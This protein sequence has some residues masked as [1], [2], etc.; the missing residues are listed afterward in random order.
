MDLGAWS[1]FSFISHPPGTAAEFG[2]V[3]VV[4]MS[5]KVPVVVKQGVAAGMNTAGLSCDMQTL[6]G[7]EYPDK[8]GGQ[9]EEEDEGTDSGSSNS[10][11]TGVLNGFFCEW[12]LSNYATAGEVADALRSTHV[13]YG[14]DALGQHFI[15]RD[16]ARNS[17]VI[18]FLKKQTLIHEDL[19]DAESGFGIVTNEPPFPWHVENVKHWLWKQSLELPD[20]TI[21]SGFYP[22]LRFLRLAS[23]KRGLPEADSYQTVIM[24]AVHL[25]NSVTIPHGDQIGTDSGAGEGANDHT[26]FGLVYDHVG[27]EGEG[28]VVYFRSYAN[29]S[30]QRIRLKDVGLDVVGG[31]TKYMPVVNG[32]DWFVDAAKGFRRHA[33][34]QQ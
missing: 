4:P 9:E 6:I 17:I 2:Y 16:A 27:E 30:L 15:L 18:E 23:L 8:P 13:V 14:P 12:A 29:Q 26:V 10:T 22:D 31:A 34:L 20:A 21:A 1:S 32:G 25:L 24:D 19:D 5:E 3:G 33:L 28:P 7:S 11:M